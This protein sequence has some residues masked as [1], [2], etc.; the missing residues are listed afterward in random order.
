MPE[1]KVSIPLPEGMTKEEFL[2]L[3]QTFQKA[4]VTGKVKD[5]ATRASIKRLIENHQAEYNSIYGEEYSKA[6]RAKV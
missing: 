6:S 3:F 1:E 5:T 4:R 2:K